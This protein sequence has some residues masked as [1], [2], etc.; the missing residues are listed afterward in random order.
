L[1]KALHQEINN[2]LSSTSNFC[3]KG[4]QIFF[5]D[6]NL[7]IKGKESQNQTTYTFVMPY[8]PTVYELYK[9][10]LEKLE[11]HKAEFEENN[12]FMKLERMVFE[13]HTNTED[14]LYVK[15][16]LMSFKTLK[17]IGLQILQ[18]TY[19]PEKTD[20]IVMRV[21]HFEHSFSLFI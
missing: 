18:N 8:T 13:T 6:P 16:R 3:S 12:E 20:R 7:N 9:G 5:N 14:E 1:K 10:Y 17:K 15:Y 21:K 11:T 19:S 4:Y 2:L